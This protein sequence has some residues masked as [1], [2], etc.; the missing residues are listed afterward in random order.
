MRKPQRRERFKVFHFMLEPNHEN[1]LK[2]HQKLNWK[3]K[4]LVVKVNFHHGCTKGK[5]WYVEKI[6]MHINLPSFLKHNV[7]KKWP[8]SWL[9]KN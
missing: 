3:K 2:K 5:G 6:Q 7:Q 1:V 8:S 9:F 4:N